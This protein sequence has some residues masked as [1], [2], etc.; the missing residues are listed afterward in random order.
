MNQQAS[1][2]T[3]TR[4][5]YGDHPSQYVRI[6]APA[7]DSKPNAASP[8][9]LAATT[10]VFLVHGGFWKHEYGLDTPAGTAAETLAPDLVARG[11]TVVEVEYR[12]YEPQEKLGFPAANDDVVNAIVFV[13][14]SSQHK[15]SVSGGSGAQTDRVVVVGMSAGGQLGLWAAMELERNHA[16]VPALT[17]AIAPIA[18]LEHAVRL[19][20]S[21]DGDAIQN[22]MDGTPEARPEQYRRACCMH[23]AQELSNVSGSILLVTG[24]RDV[25]VPAAMVRNLH[26]AIVRHLVR[27]QKCILFEFPE[28]DHYDLMRATARS[29]KLVADA[30]LQ[31]SH[32]T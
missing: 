7:R 4:V 16:I 6:W 29:W 17:V 5:A 11:C 8:E 23:R 31:P 24:G 3:Y 13:T 30:I 25:D 12:R 19:Q 21:D 26:A 20:L 22:Y 18:D 15:G 1:E 10:A 28:A 2:S 9:G 27:P 14:R 32:V